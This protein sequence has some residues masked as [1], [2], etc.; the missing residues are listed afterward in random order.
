MNH[1][2]GSKTM[3]GTP[4]LPAL[5]LWEDQAGWECGHLCQEFGA[6]TALR[7]P[8]A[9]GP[10]LTLACPL[11]LSVFLAGDSLLGAVS[12]QGMGVTLWPWG[13]LIAPLSLSSPV[14]WNWAGAYSLL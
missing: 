6:S 14:E 8:E 13:I 5:L 10:R 12:I 7:V 4:R 3:G 9:V 11:W 1:L 2:I